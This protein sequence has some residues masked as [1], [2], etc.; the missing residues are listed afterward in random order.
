MRKRGMR[1]TIRRLMLA[2]VIAAMFLWLIR[3]ADG[4]PFG[5]AVGEFAFAF[6]FWALVRGQRRRAAICFAASFVAAN[7]SIVPL[8][9]YCSA[10][11]ALVSAGPGL[12]L[13]KP[14]LPA[15]S[16]ASGRPSRSTPG[17]SF[18]DSRRGVLDCWRRDRPWLWQRRPDYQSERRWSVGVS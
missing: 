13:G 10:W 11:W 8:C 4:T 9:I 6:I 14:R 1:F 18:P 2:V 12:F 7:L 15:G 3:F 5:I 16:G 17:R